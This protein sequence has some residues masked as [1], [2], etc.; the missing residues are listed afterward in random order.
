MG[1]AQWLTPVIPVLWEAKVG[2]SPEVRSLRL[3][4]PTWWNPVSTRNTKMS[5]GWWHVPV[6]P[7]TQEAEAGELL[8]PRR[9]KSQWAEIA[10]L[11]S[12]LV[13]VWD[14]LS[15]NKKTQFMLWERIMHQKS[16]LE[17]ICNSWR[18]FRAGWLSENWKCVYKVR[19][20]LFRNVS[21]E[22]GL[23]TTRR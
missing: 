6:V 1:Q 21:R 9:Q 17:I 12:S 10:P 14:S 11:H 13:T 19:K 7:A 5:Q 2:E 8:E 4:W 16:K 23:G 3:A 22:S 20:N 15:K 18:I